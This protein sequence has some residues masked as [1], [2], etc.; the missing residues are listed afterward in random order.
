MTNYKK[1]QL[2]ATLNAI[3]RLPERAPR[4]AFPGEDGI[5]IIEWAGN[6]LEVD[7]PDRDIIAE[8]IYAVLDGAKVLAEKLEEQQKI[9]DEMRR[10]PCDAS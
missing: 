7:G 8:R 2:D 9:I 5:P 6:S 4:F 1:K 10:E 3:E